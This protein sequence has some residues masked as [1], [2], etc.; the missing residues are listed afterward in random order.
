MGDPMS[1]LPCGLS[2]LTAE[3]L[4]MSRDRWLCA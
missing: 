2:G 1:V 4:R 3:G